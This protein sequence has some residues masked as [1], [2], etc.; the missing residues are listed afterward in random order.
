MGLFLYYSYTADWWH[1]YFYPREAGWTAARPKYKPKP[2]QYKF[3]NDEDF[4][5]Y[6]TYVHAQLHELLTN[7]GPI[8]GIWF[9]PIMGYYARP[10]LFPMAE[11]YKLIRSLQ[12]Q[13]LLS[14]KQGA[15][16]TEDFAVP[17][18]SGHSLVNRVKK[19]FPQHAEVARQAW[20]ANRL[21]HNEI[22]D[23]LQP[24]GWGY[25]KTD[26]GKHKKPDHV[27]NL[28]AQGSAKLQFT[29]KHRSSAG[30]VHSSG[31]CDYPARGG[32]P[33][34]TKGFPCP[35]KTGRIQTET[36]NLNQ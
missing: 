8:A 34:S 10:D 20:L 26:D 30:R 36:E 7:Y 12:P 21:K 32:P 28:L 14:F 23:T 24:K 19:A 6:V 25:I 27:L 15:T 11:T 29:L 22:C 3:Q 13:A 33:N 4:K 17:E 35:E 1:S 31:R 2:A 16:G 9:D 18:R 5:I